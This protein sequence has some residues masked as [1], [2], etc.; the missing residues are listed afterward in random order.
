M[1]EHEPWVGCHYKVGISGQ[2]I[3]LVGYSH[4]LGDGDEDHTDGTIT[5][6]RRVMSGEWK[7]PFFTQ[8]RNYFGY[9]D[10]RLFWPYIMFF[11]YLPCCVGGA[12]QRYGHGTDEQRSVAQA[13]LLTLLEQNTPDKVLVFTRRHWA[14]PDTPC[15]NF[16]PEFPKF[17]YGTYCIRNHNIPTFFLRH[18]QGANRDLMRKAVKNVLDRPIPEMVTTK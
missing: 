6:I 9:D 2:R 8:I 11:N 16:G 14:F 3:A 10:H 18:P 5:C 17:W 7:I 12:D 13:R 1:I 15:Q 4:Y